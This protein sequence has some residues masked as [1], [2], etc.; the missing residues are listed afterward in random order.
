MTARE[1][2]LV[3]DHNTALFERVLRHLSGVVVI[4]NSGLKGLSGARNSGVALAQG[5][6]IAFLDDDAIAE[7]NWLERLSSGCQSPDVLGTGGVVEPLWMGR[8]PVW[9]PREFY[10]VIGCSYQDQLRVVTEVRNPFGGSICIRREV[11]E[12]IGGFRDGIGRIGKRPLGCE[13]TELCIRATQ[14]WPDRVFLY[15]PQ[16]RTHHHIP[17]VRTRLRYFLARCY[18]EGISKATISR[19]VG[20]KDG[21]SAERAY[22]LIALPQGVACGLRDGFFKFDLTGFLRAGAI[23]A[24]L[25][26]TTAG[27]LMGNISQSHVTRP[28]AVAADLASGSDQ[29]RTSVVGRMGK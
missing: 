29:S 6:L 16:A 5:T 14:H 24:G 10:W 7:V 2:I 18:A 15:D 13:E 20:T 11:F 19:L 22:T 21:L 8:K 17:P 26:T 4:E 27:Y 28:L 23:V 9:F 3:I 1:I 12:T 25:L